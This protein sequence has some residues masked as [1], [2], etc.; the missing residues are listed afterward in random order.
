MLLINGLGANVATWTPLVEQLDGFQLISFDAP[1]T[2]TSKSPV[3]PY[4]IAHI[5]EVAA[6]GARRGRCRARRRARLLARRRRGAATRLP[7]AR[8]RPAVDPCQQFLRHRPDPR[9]AARGVRGHDARTALR[10]ACAPRCHATGGSRARR[11]RNSATSSELIAGWHQQAAPSMMGYTLQMTAF[12]AFHSLPW[13]HRVTQPTLVM[14]GHRRQL[15]AHG[16]LGGLGG[17]PA[18]RALHVVRALG[19]L[20][21][22]R[23]RVGGRRPRSPTSSVRPSHDTSSAW[24]SARTVEPRGPAAA[25]QRRTAERAP[26]VLHQRLRPL[27]LSAEPARGEWWP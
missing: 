7:G 21:P 11:R 15:D 16:E 27:A 14:S 8:A 1:G 9:A 12:S 2:G 19:P 3:R 13:L 4:R 6:A 18:Q 17:L 25:S 20:P 23:R 22:A 10:Q 24:R 5:A 26:G